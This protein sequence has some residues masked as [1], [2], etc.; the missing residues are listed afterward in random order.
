MA[1]VKTAEVIFGRQL[2]EVRMK[3]GL[4]QEELAHLAGI[5]VSYVSQLERGLKSPSLNVLL[6]LGRALKMPAATLIR[7]V[8]KALPE[9]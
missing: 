1:A 2:R 3:Q 4:S 9:S 5:H 7:E 8:E 6:D